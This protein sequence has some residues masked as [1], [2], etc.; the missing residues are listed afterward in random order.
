MPRRRSTVTRLPDER[1]IRGL[2][3]PMVV[4]IRRDR[5]ARLATGLA[6]ATLIAAACSN[7]AA[8]PTVDQEVK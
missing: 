6:T 1:F 4:G 8:A 7:S 5:F 3:G 2:E